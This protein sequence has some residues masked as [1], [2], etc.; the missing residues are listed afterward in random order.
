MGKHLNIWMG[1]ENL[2]SLTTLHHHLKHPLRPADNGP[3]SH[4]AHKLVSL[5]CVWSVRVHLW[6]HEN[7][8]PSINYV[9][10]ACQPNNN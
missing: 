10:S 9:C 7:Y 6:R 2:V 4:S 1:P 8:Y 3:T 5:T